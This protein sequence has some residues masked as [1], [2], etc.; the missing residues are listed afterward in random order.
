MIL[1]LPIFLVTGYTALYWAW[2]RDNLNEALP[3]LP[4]ARNFGMLG[5]IGAAAALGILFSSKTFPL[6]AKT[7]LWLSIL[8]ALMIGLFSEF[9]NEG[10][11]FFR[12]L[13][14]FFAP[15]TWIHNALN[16]VISSSGDFLYRM[17]FSHWNDFLM[18]PAIV[19]I[20]YSLVFIKIYGA[21][22]NQHAP[23]LSGHALDASADLDHTLRFARILMNVGLFWFFIQ[24]WAE[25][26]GYLKNPFSNDE[27]DLPIE[28]AGT[29][30]GFWMVRVLSKPFN[31]RPE[32]FRSTFL[33]DFVCAGVVGLLY[34]LI[35][36]PLTESIASSIGHVLNPVAA[37]TLDFHEYTTLDRHMR[38]IELLLLAGM[39]WWGLNRFYKPESLTLLKTSESTRR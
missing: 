4:W 24:A 13:G 21:I 22:R 33:V 23:S 9:R 2:G 38:P 6:P 3:Y 35:V 36:G 5:M 12:N 29:M 31:E 1:S 28:F 18:G 20:L 25:K 37:N 15:G 27:I 14:H 30:L 39:T 34:T 26:A 11:F 10:K 17:E 16:R 19:S 32:H 8:A 7:R